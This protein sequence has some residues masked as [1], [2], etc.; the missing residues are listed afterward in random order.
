MPKAWKVLVVSFS[1]GL[2]VRERIRSPISLAA[3]L[4]KVRARMARSSI[5]LSN[6]WAMR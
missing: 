1:N 6:R 2:P 4:V 3:L 5:P